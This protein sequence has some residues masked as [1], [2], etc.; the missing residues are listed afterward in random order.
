ME[1]ASPGTRSFS[2]RRTRKRCAGASWTSS[3][4]SESTPRSVGRWATRGHVRAHARRT[5]EG[6]GGA[7][8]RSSSRRRRDPARNP[9]GPSS[10]TGSATHSGGENP[11]TERSGA[12]AA[13]PQDAL[14]DE[15]AGEPEN[16]RGAAQEGA[17]PGVEH[18][19]SRRRSTCSSRTRTGGR[20]HGHQ[21]SAAEQHGAWGRQPDGPGSRA[22]RPLDGRRRARP[23]EKAGTKNR[24]RTAEASSIPGTPTG[25]ARARVRDEEDGEPSGVK[26]TRFMLAEGIPQTVG[27]KPRP[28]SPRSPAEPRTKKAAAARRT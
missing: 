17:P 18:E 25:A 10:L 23:E 9:D 20:D 3:K 14:A 26:S 2:E 4:C 5:M 1:K 24:R 27:P 6:T 19:A 22:P 13:G 21:T 7:L 15:A 12:S 28:R 11:G 8:P 16:G